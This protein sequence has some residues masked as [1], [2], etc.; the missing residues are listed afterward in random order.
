ME[1]KVI[2]AIN[3]PQ[4]A[5]FLAPYDEKDEEL[6]YIPIPEE[7]SVTTVKNAKELA[8][9]LQYFPHYE[10]VIFTKEEMKEHLKEWGGD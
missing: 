2:V 4:E 8:E 10:V 9:M 1:D 6:K 5:I 3:V 7:I